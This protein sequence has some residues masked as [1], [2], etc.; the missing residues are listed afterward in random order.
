MKELLEIEQEQLN[1][2]LQ[3]SPSLSRDILQQRI[4]REIWLLKRRI[5]NEKERA[6]EIDKHTSPGGFIRKLLKNMHRLWDITHRR[7]CSV[8]V[9][10]QETSGKK[11][12]TIA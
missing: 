4:E 5:E 7:N 10:S 11:K 2:L 9:I 3:Q 12:G 1:K 6:N 8:F